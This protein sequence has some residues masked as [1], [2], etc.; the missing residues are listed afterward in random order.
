MAFD[1][2][3]CCYAKRCL[4]LRVRLNASFEEPGIEPMESSQEGCQKEAPVG[5]SNYVL[6][7]TVG[8]NIHTWLLL[9]SCHDVYSTVMP[10]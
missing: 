6:K 7:P 2:S 5:A 3:N 10:D 1:S 9:W 8:Y 4:H